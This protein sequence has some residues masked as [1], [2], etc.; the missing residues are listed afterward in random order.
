MGW[1]YKTTQK[2]VNAINSQTTSWSRDDSSV[3]VWQVLARL[4]AGSQQVKTLLRL[5]KRE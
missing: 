1:K 5:A 2:G 4:K 3:G